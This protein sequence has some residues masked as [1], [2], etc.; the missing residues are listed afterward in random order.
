MS[1]PISG[2]CK[3]LPAVAAAAGARPYASA[4]HALIPH[5]VSV[6]L[7]APAVFRRTG[8]AA[9]ERHRT[10]AEALGVDVSRCASDDGAHAGDLLAAWMVELLGR[11]GT[12][13]GLAD[14]GFRSE[15]VPALV[16][17]AL[18]QERVTKLAPVAVTRDLLED[19]FTDSLVYR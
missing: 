11:L 14:A 7:P 2:L 9:P 1:Y 12:P 3:S 8:P 5:G 4:A 13:A 18:P 16:A 15:D 19:L 6:A 17:G 10:A